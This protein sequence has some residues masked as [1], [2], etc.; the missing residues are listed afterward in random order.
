LLTSEWIV[1]MFDWLLVRS[2]THSSWFLV[3]DETSEILW[4]TEMIN[5][6]R[7]S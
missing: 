4:R 7:R 6:H 1:Y 3:K 2:S 5:C